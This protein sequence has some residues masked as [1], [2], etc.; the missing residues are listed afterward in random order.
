MFL[1]QVLSLLQFERKK[2]ARAIFFYLSL[3]LSAFSIAGSQIKLT[4]CSC[5]FSGMLL[6]SIQIMISLLCKQLEKN[7]RTNMYVYIQN[8]NQ[9]ITKKKRIYFSII[10]HSRFEKLFKYLINVVEHLQT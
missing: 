10:Y 8:K 4:E 9:L 6:I 7:V 1:T 5:F 2:N 3:S